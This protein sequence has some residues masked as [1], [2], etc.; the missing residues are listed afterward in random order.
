M[1]LWTAL[2]AVLLV[3]SFPPF[4]A[5]WLAW[6]ALVPWIWSIS[7]ATPR[8]SFL[9]GYGAGLIFF[10]GSVWWV[11]LV[12]VPGVILLVLYLALYFAVWSWFANRVIAKPERL[13]QS[14]FVLPAGWVALEYLRAHC[15]SGLGWNL[16]AHTQW[17]F[18]PVIQIADSTGVWGVS[19][20]I[21]LVNTALWQILRGLTPQ[22]I[23][24]VRP[25]WRSVFSIEL[26]LAALIFCAV[27]GYG[28]FRISSQKKLDTVKIAVVQ[29]NIPQREKWDDAFEQAI[30]KRY[31]VVVH[32]AV[33]QKPD[34]IILPETAL[35][36]YWEEPGVPARIAEWVRANKTSMLAGIPTADL[37]TE[38][39]YN[40]AVWVGADGVEQARYSKIHLVPFGEFIPL[41][42]VFGWLKEYFPIADFAPGTQWTVF[43][44]PP[45]SFSVLICFEDLFPDLARQF[46][47]RGAQSLFVITNDAWFERSA[48]SVQ[49]LQ[50]SVFRAVENRVCVGR[51]GNTG[52]S[53]FIDP[54]GRRYGAVK[55][56]KP[57]V[58]VQPVWASGARSLY[59]R[60]GD[61]FPWLCWAVVVV[62]LFAVRKGY[63][64]QI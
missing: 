3:F 29:G 46:V 28:V 63:N 21:V 59:T 64:K 45:I 54:V 58:S 14:L 30:W 12:T 48:G 17:N 57:G 22:G 39:V 9:W 42:P 7:R 52:W 31:K 55:L 27:I 44:L 18:S 38:R 5:G 23:K 62:A 24:G 8:Q 60:Y 61:W 2:S 50:A 13:K 6:I 56:F 20:L 11:G 10:G 37:Q 33:E 34:A 19:F 15:L 36:V 32:D 26:I 49:H 43:S 53:G 35:P 40:S 1:L 51:A 47:L 41:R 16:L 4:D 25:H